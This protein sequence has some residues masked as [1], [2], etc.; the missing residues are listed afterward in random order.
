MPEEGLGLSDQE[1]HWHPVFLKSVATGSNL[2]MIISL[3]MDLVGSNSTVRVP[4]ISM[5]N[6]LS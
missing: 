1:T 4:L 5:S 2:D 3:Q 6:G